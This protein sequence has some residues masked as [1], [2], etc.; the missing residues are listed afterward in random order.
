[1]VALWAEENADRLRATVPAEA[2]PLTPAA[3]LERY[4]YDA[5]WPGYVP[6]ARVKR[7]N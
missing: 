6:A 3:E 2:Q 1:M 5:I 4:F 7:Y